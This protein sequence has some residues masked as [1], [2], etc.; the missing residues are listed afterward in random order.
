MRLLIRV[1]INAIAI[2]IATQIVPG[3]V[4]PPWNTLNGIL[5]YLVIGLIFGVVN[6]LIRPIVT[7]LT[8]PLVILT[9]GLFTFLINALMLWITGQIAQW[10]G[11]NFQVN[12]FWAAVIGAL[13]VTV[14]SI[15]LSLFIPDDN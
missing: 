3:I 12:G 7:L 14:I 4:G 9:L 11:I 6:A 2:V 15:L 5:A 10:F 1:I 8:C 13:L